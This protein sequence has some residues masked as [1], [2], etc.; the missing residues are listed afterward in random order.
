MKVLITG[1]SKGIGRETAIKFLKNNHEVY[2]VDILDSKISKIEYKN[3]H[4]YISDVS[5]KEKLPDIE[6]IEILINNA[7]VQNSDDDILVNL[8]GIINCTEKYLNKKL[9]S[10][11]NLASVSATNGAEFPEYCASKGG[12][13]S[14]TR[15]IAK[16][17]AKQGATCNSISFGG[18]YTELNKSV[19]E[20][21]DAWRDIM[22]MT[23][24]RKWCTVEEA[25]EW[26]YFV[27]VI[28]KSMTAQDI[29]I[30]NG[31]MYNHTFVWR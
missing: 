22:N 30:D 31:E 26:I 3:Y 14:Y 12:V 25:A 13:I 8:K 19:I 29:I 10:I 2:G 18:V 17:I 16:M 9:K 4:H 24:L 7:G 1:T 5:I 6:N 23:P 28:N 15:C 27:S 11:V 20:D 21:N